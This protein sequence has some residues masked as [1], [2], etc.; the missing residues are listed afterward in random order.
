[1]LWKRASRLK[2]LVKRS[3]AAGDQ[4]HD[5]SAGMPVQY[6]RLSQAHKASLNMNEKSATQLAAL[7]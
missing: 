4:V 6:V 3:Q 5:E 2:L 1:M 7:N